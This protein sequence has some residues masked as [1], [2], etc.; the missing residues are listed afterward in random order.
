MTR[1]TFLFV[2][3]ATLGACSRAPVVDQQQVTAKYLHGGDP[4]ITDP[5]SPAWQ[6]AIEHRARLMV[7][8]VT[9]PRLT[10]PG[11]E[12]VQVR[13]LHD[14]Q[15]IVVRLEWEDATADMVPD[16]GRGSDAAAVQF[17]LTGGPDVP[18]PAMGQRGK[19]VQICYWQAA[20]QADLDRAESGAGDRIAALHPNLA[21]DHY[22]FEANPAAKAEMERRYAP[23][24]AAGNPVTTQSSRT[25]VQELIAEGFGTSTAASSQRADG[26]GAWN[27]GRWVTT[28]AKPLAEDGLASLRVGAK[29]Y[30]AIAIWDGA[31]R[32]A[33]ARKMRSGWIPLLVEAP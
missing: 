15:W 28:I 12:L 32:H 6:D 4:P 29:T 22:P 17:P 18:D 11:V 19:A 30:V 8:D 13:A 24:Q 31:A 5:A 10:K 7:Q 20:W 3:L 16:V 26:R 23:A 27:R 2:A 21:I 14:G 1:R 9:E 33:G 25:P